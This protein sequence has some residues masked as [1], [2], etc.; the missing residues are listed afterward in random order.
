MPWYPVLYLHRFA[1]LL[2]IYVETFEAPCIIHAMFS[3]MNNTPLHQTI[4]W[5]KWWMRNQSKQFHNKK[6]QKQSKTSRKETPHLPL[7]IF[8]AFSSGY[9][10]GKQQTTPFFAT[11]LKSCPFTFYC[12]TLPRICDEGPQSDHRIKQVDSQNIIWSTV[13]GVMFEDTS[14]KKGVT[15]KKSEYPPVNHPPPL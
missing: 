14:K 13:L 12:F 7:L 4:F 3:P 9:F 11:L 5:Q 8:F 2:L 6:Q 15:F 1:L 10:V